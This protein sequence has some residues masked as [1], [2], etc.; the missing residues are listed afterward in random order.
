VS[1]TPVG[2]GESPLE[3]VRY[4]PPFDRPSFSLAELQFRVSFGPHKLRF[5]VHDPRSLGSGAAEAAHLLNPD[6]N[7]LRGEAR[8]TVRSDGTTEIA[9]AFV[10]DEF[11]ALSLPVR[12]G[13]AGLLH[14]QTCL[15]PPRSEPY[16]LLV[17]LA[18]HR[19]KHF[20]QK[21]EEWQMWDPG[22]SRTAMRQWEEARSIFAEAILSPD[23][24]ECERLAQRSLERSIEASEHLAM[25][26]AEIL[27]HRRFG[28][29]AASSTT[30]GVGVRPRTVATPAME[31]ALARDFDVLHLRADWRE[32][33]PKRGKP[34]F[35]HLDRWIAWAAARKKPV[36]LGPLLDLREAA[37]PDHARVYRHDYESFRNLAYDHL[38]RVVA[39]YANAVGIWNV[40]SGFH[41]N[42][43]LELSVEQMID[44]ARRVVVLV[45]QRNRRANT[46]MELVDLFGEISVRNAGPVLPWRYAEILQQEG[47]GVTA[48]GLRMV[49]GRKGAVARDL[50]QIS[51]ILDRFLGREARV[52]L[53]AFG[54]PGEMEDKAGGFWHGVDAVPGAAPV[55]RGWTPNTQASWAGRVM[56]VSL[57]KPFVEATLWCEAN[58]SDADSRCFGLFD[59]NGQPRPVLAKLSALRRRLRKPLGPRRTETAVGNA[60]DETDADGEA[61]RDGGG[62]QE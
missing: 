41:A 54:V 37:L 10:D 49:L 27:L 50:F 55:E 52:M 12:A 25:S 7:P 62:V 34:D 14:L 21:C 13:R 36:M 8:F 2:R 56:S 60:A 1:G 59:G 38:D 24:L 20:I 22:L 4:T 18:R 43:F 47:I 3:E 46:L 51:C 16:G 26:H 19:I 28:A 23:P 33:E 5:R 58:D 29:K 53:S 9:C 6:D 32:L 42:A 17:E 40:G 48:L 31:E 61:I 39:R 11:A 15:L 30:L 35:T 45:R 57:S 44:L